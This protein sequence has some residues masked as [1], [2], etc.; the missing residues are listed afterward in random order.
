MCLRSAEGT[1]LYASPLPAQPPF[2]TV[3]LGVNIQAHK[4]GAPQ[5]RLLIASGFW[6]GHFD[7]LTWLSFGPLLCLDV[8]SPPLPPLGEL[9]YASVQKHHGLKLLKL[10]WRGRSLKC[11]KW[12][13]CKYGKSSEDQILVCIKDSYRDQGSVHPVGHYGSL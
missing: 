10:P 13:A 7:C 3:A 12:L 9:P 2:N 11:L 1:G 4:L 5:H 6:K 8:R